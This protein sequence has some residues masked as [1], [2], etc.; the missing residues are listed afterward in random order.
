MK[1]AN[2][3]R[4]GLVVGRLGLGTMNFGPH[5]PEPEAHAIM[6]LAL[7]KGVNLFDTA[8]TYGAQLGEG[9]TEQIIGNWLAEDPARR[10]QI[11]LATK[12]YG[13]MGL[14]PN[15][16]RLSAFHVRKACEDSLRRLR[17]DHIDLLQ[18]HHIDRT[19]PWEETWQ[20]LD[21]LVAQGKVT[22]V[23]TS[24]FA[25]W[26][27]A[28]AQ[29][30]ARQRNTPGPVSE[31]SVYNLLER[32]VELEVLPACRDYGIGLLPYSPLHGGL[33]GGA[34]RRGT[35]DG[36]AAE[37]KSGKQLKRHHDRIAAYEKWCAD[38][39]LPPAQVALAWL[40][41]QPG[42]TA[43]ILG[44][45]VAEQLDQGLAAL[46]I[47]LD[48]GQLKELDALFPGPGGPAPEAYSW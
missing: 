45:R 23:G 37:P 38:L 8:N 7:D 13:M 27:L 43:P 4:S 17:T 42:V 29:E 31:Q 26:H 2:L 24:N 47:S 14:K 32:T 21:L 12:V 9:I 1:Y 11:V 15:A 35:A 36:R 25:G 6:N 18:V 3:G 40:L 44:P 30:H 5:T 28:R 46:K 19:T 34:V 10:D 39:G 16:G 41:H 20:A 22:Y 48:R 33:L